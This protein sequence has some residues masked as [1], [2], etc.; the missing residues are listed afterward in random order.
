MAEKTRNNGTLTESAFWSFIR[1]TLRAKTIYWKPVKEAKLAARKSVNGKRHKYEYQC[2]ECKGWFK[3]KDVAVDHIIGAGSLKSA[4]DLEGFIERLFIEK[5]GLQVLC[6]KHHKEK[7]Y[8]ERYG[9][10]R[11]KHLDDGSRNK[12]NIQ[13]K[14][15]RR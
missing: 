12:K 3:D 4:K 8:F 6:Q 15:N 2:A 10:E 13:R 5:E 11:P 1:S 7:T 14:T 9:K